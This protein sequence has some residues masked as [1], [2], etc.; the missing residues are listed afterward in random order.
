[1]DLRSASQSHDP[2]QQTS[3]ISIPQ[4]SPDLHDA[5]RFSFQAVVTLVWPFSSSNRVFSLLLAERD[6]RL[7]NQ[8]GQIRVTFCE[9]CAEQVA[10]TKVGIGDTVTLSLQGAQWAENTKIQ[11]TPGKS[12]SWELQYKNRLKFEV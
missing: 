7:R 5:E 2:D 4:L 11:S 12:L 9:L 8:N 3:L 1:M 10:L 6:F